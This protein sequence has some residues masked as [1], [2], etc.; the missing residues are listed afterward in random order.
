MTRSAT[1]RERLIRAANHLIH[2]QGFKQTTLADIAAESGVP[3]GNL[4]YYF[5]TKKDIGQT[6]A[7]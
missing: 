5:K 7:Q 2:S 6:I 1:K 4:Y 3:P